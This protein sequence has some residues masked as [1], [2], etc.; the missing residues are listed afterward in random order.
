[1]LHGTASGVDSAVASFGGVVVFCKSATPRIRRVPATQLPARLAVVIVNT[2]R[3]RSTKELVSKVRRLCDAEARL[4]EHLLCAFDEIAVRALQCLATAAAAPPRSQR[5]AL[6]PLAPL[7]SVNQ[8]LLQAI[9]V[10]HAS[11][12]RAVALLQR[13]QYAGK[14]TGAGGGGCVLGFALT[15]ENVRIK[16]N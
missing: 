3:E 2:K 4:A 11:N 6:A 5:T 14:I 1:M 12:E 13:F 16:K 9:G 15:N 8:A 10:S 7:I